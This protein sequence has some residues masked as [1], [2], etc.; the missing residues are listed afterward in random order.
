M[1]K[2]NNLFSVNKPIIAMIHVDALPGTPLHKSSPKEIVKKALNEAQI[3]LKHG[4]HGLMIE[5]MHD[6]PYLKNEV[7]HEISSLMS[8]V[9]YE[10]KQKIKVPCGIQI[11]AGANNAA[12]AVAKSAELDFI[13]AEGFVFA[14]VADEGIIES[15]AG[16]LL[17]YRKSINAEDVLILT[18]IKKKHSSHSIT[19]DVSLLQTAE[20]AS[21]FL[22]DGII[23][24][25][26]S[27]GKEPNVADL[28][29][30]YKN[31]KLPII[32]GSGIT[33]ENIKIFLPY[34]DACIIG[35]YFKKDGFWSNPLDE[36]RIKKFMIKYS[37]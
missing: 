4:I 10:L 24:T 33:E 11:L 21:F 28:E 6:V 25:G 5:N 3:Y 31:S 27:T 23:I 9:G 22:S 32:A 17:R 15:S 34:I 14:H 19:N 8:I 18:D 26:D 16:K 20:A 12:M 7:G 13:R 30:L 35:S 37:S 2:F 29:F 1:S 36:T